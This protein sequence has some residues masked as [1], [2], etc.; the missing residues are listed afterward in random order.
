MVGLKL[1]D[2]QQECVDKI[3]EATSIG[4]KKEVLIKSPTGSGKT[5]ILI[6]Y[7]D[8][9]LK[10]NKNAIFIWLTPRSRRTRRTKQ[11]KNEK[12]CTQ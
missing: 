6:D 12:I 3:I 8:E 2:F 7:I 5:I 4:I 9:Y 1:K 11:N 10:E